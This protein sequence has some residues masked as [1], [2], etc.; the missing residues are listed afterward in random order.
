MNLDE[1]L[2][3][4][5]EL[6]TELGTTQQTLEDAEKE[7]EELKDEIKDLESNIDSKNREIDDLESEN[8][9]YLDVDNQLSELEES[10]DIFRDPSNWNGNRFEPVLAYLRTENPYE[11]L[12]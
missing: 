9:N 6:E 7:V 5:E 11:L 3:K 4:I 1:A 10:V 8:K 12:K 2:A